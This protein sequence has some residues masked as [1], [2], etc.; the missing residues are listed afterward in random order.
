[1]RAFAASYDRMT[2]IISA[3]C[4]ALAAAL[5]IMTGSVAAAVVLLA[6]FGIAFLW[7][8]LGYEIGEGALVVRRPTGRVR[9]PLGDI[10]E[11]RASH[12]DDFTGC[13]RLW[14]SGGLFGYF[15]LYRTSKLG[16]SWWYCTSRENMV[17]VRT[18][19]QTLVLSPDDPEAFLTAV[20]HTA[21]PR[22]GIALHQPAVSRIA[23]VFGALF[24]AVVL[25]GVAFAFLYS[26]GAPRYSLSRESL[27]I[28]DPFYAVT[29]KATDVDLAHARIVDVTTDPAW[30]PTGR[31]NGFANPHYA[32]GWF[33][34][35]G[36]AKVRMYRAG[37]RRLVLLPP[38]GSGP[39]ILYQ[40]ADP[41]AFLAQLRSVW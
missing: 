32:S 26:P 17:I 6:A 41:E 16:K 40:A 11:V 3:F 27:T 28:H 7:S 36:G 35:A 12:A 38:K 23:I 29:V 2:K 4:L 37:G 21:S 25:G 19:T 31:T 15:G 30:R 10:R 22:G 9:I 20:G 18:E 14:G 33:S 13:I 5:G 39:A 24:A 1:M 34:V 8:P